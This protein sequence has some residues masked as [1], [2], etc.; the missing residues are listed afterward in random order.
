MSVSPAI[1]F[2]I[3]RY[4]TR[5][6]EENPLTPNELQDKVARPIRE[7]FWNGQT[8]LYAKFLK[9]LL[10]AP[11]FGAG[12]TGECTSGESYKTLLPSRG[13]D[14][15]FT[16][17]AVESPSTTALLRRGAAGMSAR[18]GWPREPPDQKQTTTPLT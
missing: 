16:S 13:K 10:G 8:P 1:L 9:A 3:L 14:A 6:A 2:G 18:R 12:D 17:A 5:L 11:I 4:L 15:V 7:R